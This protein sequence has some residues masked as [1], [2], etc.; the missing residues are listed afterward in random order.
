[1]IL[2]LQKNKMRRILLKVT[3]HMEK[4]GL[5]PRPFTCGM[6]AFIYHTIRAQHKVLGQWESPVVYSG[7]DDD[8]FL[9]F[10]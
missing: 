10:D 9:G 8:A 2:I 5:K 4:Q 3:Q 6:Q 1:M 7:E